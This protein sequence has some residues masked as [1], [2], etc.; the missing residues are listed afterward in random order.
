[1]YF[2]FT[3]GK[4]SRQQDWGEGKITPKRNQGGEGI[5]ILIRILIPDN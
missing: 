2:S 1:M 4:H 5:L 3:T